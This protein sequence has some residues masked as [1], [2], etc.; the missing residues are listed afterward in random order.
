MG[1]FGGRVESFLATLAPD[2]GQGSRAT[3]VDAE[4]APAELP[5]AVGREFAANS[6]HAIELTA[7]DSLAER[8]AALWAP[9]DEDSS[10][11]DAAAWRASTPAQSAPAPSSVAAGVDWFDYAK[12]VLAAI[13]VVAIVVQLLRAVQ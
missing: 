1:S 4:A 10:A 2:I 6:P 5:A 3:L 7:P 8:P 13:G 11:V 9:A 12:S